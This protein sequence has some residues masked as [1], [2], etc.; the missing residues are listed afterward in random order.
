MLPAYVV[1][2]YALEN[3]SRFAFVELSLRCIS[4]SRSLSC[5]TTSA[6][7]RET[8]F[9]LD[10][11]FSR[12]KM[13]FSSFSTSLESRDISAS[14][15]HLQFDGYYRSTENGIG[16]S[17]TRIR[18]EVRQTENERWLIRQEI[19]LLGDSNRNESIQFVCRNFSHFEILSEIS[20]SVARPQLK[21]ALHKVAL[22]NNKTAQRPKR[23]FTTVLIRHGAVQ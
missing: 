19:D 23:W 12:A 17:P 22:A 2:H 10:S 1:Y 11:F 5:W 18:Y 4:V 3:S 15:N 6:G 14:K 16:H 7:A 20:D 21:L 9:S 8:K 13:A